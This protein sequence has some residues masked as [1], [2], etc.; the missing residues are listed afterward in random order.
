M[1]FRGSRPCDAKS[2]LLAVALND[3]SGSGFCDKS[4]YSITA[5]TNRH[6]MIYIHPLFRAPPV[7][8][9]R[10]RVNRVHY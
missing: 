2:E 5:A 7:L 1:I 4:P 8:V 10:R 6:A 9:V 3:L